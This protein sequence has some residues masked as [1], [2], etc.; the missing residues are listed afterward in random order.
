MTTLQTIPELNEGLKKLKLTGMLTC[1]MARN[2]EAVTN[3]MSHV[4][5]LM[6]LIQD[7]LLEREQR[8]YQRQY[9]KANFKGPKTIENFDF[10]FNPK[11]NQAL[12]RDLATCRFIK[13]KSPVLIM[14]PCGTGKSHLAQALGHCALQQG[15]EVVCTTQTQLS[16]EIQA[17]KATN[18]YRRK[19]KALAKL[20][21][22]I[23]DDFGLK[24]L[25]SPQDEDLHELIV[26]RYEQTST[27]LTSNLALDEWQQA[28]SNQLLAVATIDRLRHNAYHVILE[29]KSY[30]SGRKK[31][32][33]KKGV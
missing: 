15:Y 24:P 12:I 2:Q 6:L 23:I 25:R 17:A 16:E 29:G 26:Q 11:I 7:E 3:Q 4:E 1:L 8:R 32:D 10:N 33:P 30:R 31:L 28:F 18:S 13:E 9:K 21:V 19:M 5:F 14:G 27:I 20:P 22:L